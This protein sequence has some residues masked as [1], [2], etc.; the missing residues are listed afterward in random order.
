MN[1]LL[2]NEIVEFSFKNSP[3]TN[4]SFSVHSDVDLE[5]DIESIRNADPFFKKSYKI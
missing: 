1:V 4:L 5:I 2:I 3:V